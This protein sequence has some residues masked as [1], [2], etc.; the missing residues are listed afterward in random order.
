[1]PFGFDIFDGVPA[2]IKANLDEVKQR[3]AAA[4][5]RAGRN[6]GEIKLVAVSKTH[7]AEVL[8]EAIAAGAECSW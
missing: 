7:P 6:A 2:D 3:V 1:M 4:S 5:E 8:R